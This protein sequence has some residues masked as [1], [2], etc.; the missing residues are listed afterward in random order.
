MRESYDEN[1][2]REMNISVAMTTYNGE[3]YIRVQLD[4][5]LSQLTE[6][7]EVIVCDDGSSDKTIEIVKE[8]TFKHKNVKLFT[9][10]RLGVVRNFQ[11]AIEKCTKELIFLS[12]QDD[13]W[14]EEKVDLIRTAFRKGSAKLISHN[15]EIFCEEDDGIKGQLITKMHHGVIRNLM[16]SSYWGCC[17]AFKKEIV[18]F[19]LPFPKGIVAHDQWIGLIVEGKKLSEFINKPLIRH[20][21]HHNNVSKPLSLREKMLFRGNMIAGLVKHFFSIG[22]HN[23]V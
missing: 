13:I 20:R 16:K 1:A 8:Y 18:T 23:R 7:D 15:A 11:S 4:S 19:F 17:M 2:E 12:D 22:K 9:N 21:V 6:E 14:C 5:I 10:E 3:K